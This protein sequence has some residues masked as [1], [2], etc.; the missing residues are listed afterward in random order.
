MAELYQSLS[1]SK[2][3]CKYHIIFVP[4]RGRKAIFGQTRCHLDRFPCAG[5]AKGVSDY[6][7]T[8]DAGPCA[9]VHRDSPK[10]PVAS[11]MDS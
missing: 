11:V 3:D 2:W 5:Q 4:K 10:Q 9:Y 8:P 6:H 7:G 1:H